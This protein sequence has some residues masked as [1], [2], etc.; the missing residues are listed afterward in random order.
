MDITKIRK[1]DHVL[2]RAKVSFAGNA[3]AGED[4]VYAKFGYTDLAI[5]PKDIVGHEPHFEVNEAVVHT[6]GSLGEILKVRGS[7]AVVLWE[8]GGVDDKVPLSDL[9]IFAEPDGEIL[10][11]PSGRPV[12]ADTAE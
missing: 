6:D 10:S 8:G 12:T 11:G 5:V 4:Y 2:I 3:G 7:T 9:S 1:N